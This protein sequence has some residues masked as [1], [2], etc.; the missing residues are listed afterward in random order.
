[1]T[2]L[3]C[4]AW[5]PRESV[6][7]SLRLNS[8]QNLAAP[9]TGNPV[10]WWR[11]I[12]FLT[13]FLQCPDIHEYVKVIEALKHCSMFIYQV[14]AP[15]TH[16]SRWINVPEPLYGGCNDR[17]RRQ[18]W[19]RRWRRRRRGRQAWDRKYLKKEEDNLARE[20]IERASRERSDRAG[21]WVW[22][23]GWPP[24]HGRL[25]WD[26]WYQKLLTADSFNAF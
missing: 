15:G 21:G 10:A 22:E 7:Y 16:L 26:F 5:W 12:P 9:P 2:A 24:F 1:M 18:K 11:I 17:R 19:W 13:Q 23:G 6:E 3:P 14:Y 25:F 8:G 4:V 20:R